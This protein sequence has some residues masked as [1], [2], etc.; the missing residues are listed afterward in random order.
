[1]PS[2]TV[3]FLFSDIEGST[4]RWEHHHVA[5][6]EAVA[7]HDVLIRGEIERHGGFVFRTVG[8]CAA[9]GTPQQAL[10]AALACQQRVHAEDFSARLVSA[11][12]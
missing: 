10:Q 2:G 12:S 7:R 3:T 9:F 1:M 5:M 11:A 4:H 6:T 8:F